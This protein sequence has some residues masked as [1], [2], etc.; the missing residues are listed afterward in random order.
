[1]SSLLLVGDYVVVHPDSDTIPDGAVLVDGDRVVAVGAAP[2]LRARAPDAQQLGGRG[3][4]VMPGLIDAHEHGHGVTNVQG[5][6]PDGPLERWLIRLRGLWPMDTYAST[7]LAAL[8]LLRTGVTTVLHHHAYAGAQPYRADLEASLRAYAALGIRATFALD[9]RDRNTYVY[10]PDDQWL[11]TLPPDLAGAIR[12]RLP[13]PAVPPAR[14][15]LS[16]LPELEHAWAS[17]RLKLALGP[18]GG[19]WCSE[20]SLRLVAAARERGAGV[21]MH[22]LETRLQRE[23]FTRT[24]GRSA[25]AW[26]AE[27]GLVGPNTSLAHGVWV[28]EADLDLLAAGGATLVHNPASNLRLR[29]GVAPVLAMLRHRIPVAVGMDGAS[30]SD[31]GDY[32][33]DLRLCRA[34]HFD[35]DGALTSRDVWRMV[36]RAGARAT[37]WGD[38]IGQL[39]PGCLADALIVRL[40]EE[41]TVAPVDPASDLLDRLLRETTPADV[42][43]VVVGG[44]VV[45]RDGRS[46][47]VDEDAILRRIE[48]AAAAADAGAVGERRRLLAAVEEAVA[49]FYATWE[50]PGNHHARERDNRW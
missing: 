8:R 33:T 34:L 41:P 14:E 23:Y 21:H 31:R 16:L 9:L 13:P 38:A 19:Q 28:S 25:P 22:L 44:R 46:T 47:L 30:L 27:L 50:P 42:R 37:F 26:L 48:A 36:F 3:L 1:V 6:V 15:V 20:G 17:D 2:E 4:V 45:L 18:R 39:A 32:F 49:S 29:S 5:G 24:Y 12:E 10:A 11:A 43:T 35:A 7:A 40:A